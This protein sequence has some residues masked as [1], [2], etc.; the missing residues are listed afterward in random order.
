M[1]S[2]IYRLRVKSLIPCPYV[3]YADNSFVDGE[4]VD[5][6]LLCNIMLQ[7]YKAWVFMENLLV[8]SCEL[9]NLSIN[10]LVTYKNC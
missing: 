5:S 7:G 8:Q 10:A 1:H 3:K 9:P 6:H 4:C 2:H